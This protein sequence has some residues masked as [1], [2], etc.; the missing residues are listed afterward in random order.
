MQ[1]LNEGKYVNSYESYLHD[2]PKF[3]LVSF[4]EFIEKTI[5]KSGEI[6]MSAAQILENPILFLDEFNIFDQ[7][8]QH[9]D[10]NQSIP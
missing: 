3:I 7:I 10:G 6:V 1:E 8:F 2:Q 4:V 5:V 9:F